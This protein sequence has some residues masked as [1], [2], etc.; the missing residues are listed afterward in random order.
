MKT[1]TALATIGLP[2]TIV[3]GFFGMNFEV[4]PWIREPWGVAAATALMLAIAGLLL[5]FF[6]WRRWL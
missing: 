3:S 1:L 4:L 2:F 6:R 5:A